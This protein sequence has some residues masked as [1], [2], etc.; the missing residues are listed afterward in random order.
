MVSSHPN[1]FVVVEQVTLKHSDGTMESIEVVHA[2]FVLGA[3]GRDTHHFASYGSLCDGRRSFLDAIDTGYKHGRRQHRSDC[4]SLQRS[5]VSLLTHSC[6]FY[7]G[8]C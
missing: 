4:I 3:D 5:T 8:C 6:R 2:K 1:D 7:L